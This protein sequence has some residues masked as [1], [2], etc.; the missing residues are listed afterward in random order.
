MCQYLPRRTSVVAG[1]GCI[2]QKV[3]LHVIVELLGRAWVEGLRKVLHLCHEVVHVLLNSGEIQRKALRG[4]TPVRP[5]RGRGCCPSWL[6]VA[7]TAEPPCAK[8]SGLHQ[9]QQQH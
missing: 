4:V 1:D 9:H 7:A 5:V 8:S 6:W 2:L 3:Q